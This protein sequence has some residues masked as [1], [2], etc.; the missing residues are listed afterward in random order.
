MVCAAPLLAAPSPE[1]LIYYETDSSFSTDSPWELRATQGIDFSN[2]YAFLFATGLGA[3]YSLDKTVSLGVEGSA[4]FAQQ[5]ASTAVLEDVLNRYGYRS[6]TV[7]PEYSAVGVIRLTPISG[8]VNFLSRSVLVADISLLL[9]GGLV[10]YRTLGLAPVIGTGLE[11]HLGISSHFGIAGSLL[12]DAQQP[13]G[14]RWES[15][16]GFRLAPTWRF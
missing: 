7:Y 16:V 6:D 11:V 8:L 13:P 2:P 5:R 12:W 1:E 3:S 9:R 4:Y 15:R 14:Y 10:N